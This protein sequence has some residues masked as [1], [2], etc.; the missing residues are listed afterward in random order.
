MKQKNGFF[1]ILL[2]VLT[3]IGEALYHYHYLLG[4]Y[5]LRRLRCFGRFVAYVT[6]KP[7]RSLRYAWLVTI[8]RPVHRFLARGQREFAPCFV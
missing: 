5:V 3:A 6:Y 8:V 2:A 1:A 4:A 7:R